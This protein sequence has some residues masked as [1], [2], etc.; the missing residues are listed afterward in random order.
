MTFLRKWRNMNYYLYRIKFTTA[1]HIGSDTGTD[2][3][4]G[5]EYTIHADTLFSAVCCE[6]YKRGGQSLI[7]YIVKLAS[8]NKLLLTD[9]FPYYLD[10]RDEEYYIPKPILNY[11]PIRKKVNGEIDTKAF[12]SMNYIRVSSFSEYI[13]SLKGTN[14]FNPEP[15]NAR[16]AS[17]GKSELR[18]C[19][20]ITGKDESLPYHI[21]V[22]SFGEKWGLY[23][24]ASFINS[25]DKIVFE[26][27]LQQLSLSGIGGKRAIGLGKFETDDAIELDDAYTKDQEELFRMM[28]DESAET[29]VSLGVCFPEENE[30]DILDGAG[31][32][33]VRRGGFVQSHIYSDTWQKKKVLYVFGAGSSF[34]KRF[35]GKVADVSY[36]GN[37]AVYRYLKPIFAGVRL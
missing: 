1:V 28:K 10:E 35:S 22:F 8:E 11:R 20:A 13:D 2:P 21:G 33:L 14:V 37:H 12:K 9:M 23:F 6:A 30:S 32:L 18:T 16:L 4:I 7:D 15:T 19:V 17:I 36:M 3:L 25:E 24:I 29:Q 34:K 31:Y 5:S 26:E 27:L